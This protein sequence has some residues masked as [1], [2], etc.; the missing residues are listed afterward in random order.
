M[1]RP[2][3]ADVVARLTPSLSRTFKSPIPA[4]NPESPFHWPY[5]TL[6]FPFIFILTGVHCHSSGYPLG[7]KQSASDR[8][9]RQRNASESEDYVPVVR[10]CFKVGL[11]FPSTGRG[12]NVQ[13]CTRKAKRILPH[14]ITGFTRLIL[15]RTAATAAI[16]DAGTVVAKSLQSMESKSLS[17]REMSA[18]APGP[19]LTSLFL[20][21][22]L[23]LYT[24]YTLGRA[25]GFLG[26][27]SALTR[28]LPQRSP[29]K[30][31]RGNQSHPA[32][33]PSLGPSSAQRNHFIQSFF[34][35][36]ERRWYPPVHPE[37]P[38]PNSRMSSHSN[39]T[40]TISTTAPASFNSMMDGYSAVDWGQRT[41]GL[42]FVCRPRDVRKVG[43]APSTRAC[44]RI[45]EE[46]VMC[47]AGHVC[48]TFCALLART[49][50]RGFRVCKH[51]HRIDGPL[52]KTESEQEVQRQRWQAVR[53]CWGL[54][55]G[56]APGGTKAKLGSM[57]RR[58]IRES[59]ATASA[60][61]HNGE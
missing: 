9:V 1:Q 31:W 41:S 57:K 21:I 33:I 37:D 61:V 50:I 32:F 10:G 48:S 23:R 35:E 39:S 25:D 60:S 2:L 40:P 16:L 49:H 14:K 56:R 19:F 11:V 42:G 52:D 26:P 38:S 6:Q 13:T 12:S 43:A 59:C 22:C 8:S 58:R 5:N 17:D 54:R 36:H 30:S 46:K 18:H 47:Q 27:S 45:Y 20:E 44:A 4:Y 7:F 3:P 15:C 53:A 55:A 34:N 29:F 28:V 24:I 51:V